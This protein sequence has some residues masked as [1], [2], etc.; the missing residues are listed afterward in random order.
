[1]VLPLDFHSALYARVS[2][3]RSAQEGSID[4]QLAALRQRRR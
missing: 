2:S 4:S 1:M 3:G